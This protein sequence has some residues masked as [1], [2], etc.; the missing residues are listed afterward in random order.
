MAAES[1]PFDEISV[2]GPPLWSDDWFERDA[3]PEEE[4]EPTSTTDINDGD[5]VTEVC[6]SQEAE[7][8]YLPTDS[9]GNNITK[10]QEHD[11]SSRIKRRTPVDLN[12]LSGLF[13]ELCKPNHNPHTLITSLE[14]GAPLDE[15]G[16][17]W[18]QPFQVIVHPQVSFMCDVHAHMCSSEIIGLLA[19]KWDSDANTLYIQAPFPCTATDRTDDGSTDVELDPIAEF[20]VREII[21]NEG[22]T[23][24]GWYHSHPK[25]RPDPS[26]S[27]DPLPH[28]V[29]LRLGY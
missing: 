26:V 18:E 20:Q 17:R 8:E 2:I 4:P 1:A 27:L 16:L 6:R 7:E 29:N 9:S 19:G 3:I 25:F 13:N 11:Q 24:V 28:C 14:Y 5:V 23:V 15:Q 10:G 22:M 21:A 12:S